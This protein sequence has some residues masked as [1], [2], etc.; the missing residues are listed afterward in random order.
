MN[1][2]SKSLICNKIILFTVIK[3]SSLGPTIDSIHAN[4][5]LLLNFK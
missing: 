4:E 2:S 1:R 3:A 5:H